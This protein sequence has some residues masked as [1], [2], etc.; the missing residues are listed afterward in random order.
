MPSFMASGGG[1]PSAM[2]PGTPNQYDPA[3]G[4]IPRVPNPGASASSA[5]TS[6]LGNMSNLYSL[7]TG[8]GGASGSGVMAALGKE[9]PGVSGSIGAATNNINELLSG[10]VPGDVIA[11]LAQH[12]AEIGA[13]SGMGPMGPNTNAGYLKALGL[14]SLGMKQ[15]GQ[16][17]LDSLMTSVPR[18]PAFD[19]SSMM[20][21]PAQQQEAAYMSQVLANAPVPAAAARANL[22]A[23]RTGAGFG[24]GPSAPVGGFNSPIRGGPAFPNSPMLTA[25]NI[26]SNF[27]VGGSGGGG[28][29]PAGDPYANW[30]R[31]ASTWG[32]GEGVP[33]MSQEDIYNLG[34]SPA[35]EEYGGG[36]DGGS[37]QYSD[38]Y[39]M[40]S[41]YGE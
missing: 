21:T 36:Y 12:A 5:I 23:L 7:A 35:E 34:L 40:D 3:Y 17:S 4:G 29:R 31:L 20:V 32:T 28:S 13:G 10:R 39:S 37:D 19:P 8:A 22:D 18:A 15:Q 9:I 11:Q 26:G 6:N 16:Q 2:L 14:T 1:S 38:P 33:G 30:Q 41:I 24:R 27:T 25:D